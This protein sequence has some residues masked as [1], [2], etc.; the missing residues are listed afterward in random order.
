MLIPSHHLSSSVGCPPPPPP[1]PRPP[2]SGM[3]KCWVGC[4]CKDAAEHLPW[5]GCT[6]VGPAHA[7]V[8]V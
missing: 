5:E 2:L 4:Q 8:H 3:P 6:Q 1:P 7:A